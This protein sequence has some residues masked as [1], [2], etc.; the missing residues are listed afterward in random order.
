MA[1]ILD[2]ATEKALGAFAS[3]ATQEYL[4][5]MKE[6]RT[7][8]S[9]RCERCRHLAWPPRDFCPE[10]HH[11][12]VEWTP[13]GPQATL[14]AFTQQQRSL[15]FARPEVIGVVEI[16]ELGRILTAI[17]APFDELEVGMPMVA[18]FVDIGEGVLV[19]RF[20]RA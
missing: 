8:C 10:C 6:D 1:C 9:T 13:L 7:L 17:D 14:H 5:R 4:R 15:R 19:H 16:P 18:D 3:A 12:R 20:K 11:D 2:L